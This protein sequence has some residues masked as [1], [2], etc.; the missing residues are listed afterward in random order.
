[1]I[2]AITLLVALVLSLILCLLFVPV[3]RRLAL[4][5]GL[6]DR[7]DGNRKIHD[8]TTPVSG[9]VAVLL[10]AVFT[11]TALLAFPNDLQEQLADHGLEL[12]GLLLGGLVIGAVGVVDDFCRLRGHY[13]LLGQIAAIAVVLTFCGWVGEVKLFGWIINFEMLG[14]GWFGIVFTMFL[15]LGAVNSL[16]LLDGMDGL[17]SSI[18]VIL[19]LALAAMAVSAGH[20]WAGVVAIAL[21]GALI[22]FL[23]YNLPPATIFLGDAGSM[24][25]G[26]VLGT[27]V[28]KCSLK[29]PATFVIALPVGLL[30]LPILD[31]TAAIVRRKLTGRSIYTTDRGH[32]HHSLLR[33]G[34][35]TSGVLLLV[36]MLSLVTCAGVLASQAFDNEWIAVLTAVSI[37]AVL[38]LT[39][40]FGHAEAVLIKNRLLSMLSP[41][42]H[43][44]QM[45]VRLQGSVAW[46]DL[47]QTLKVLAGELNLEQ[48]LLDVN[49]PALHE[50]YHA[51]W[52]HPHKWSEEI[53]LWHLEIPV[54]VRGVS[55]GRLV[56]AGKPDEQPVWSKIAIV[57]K[58]VDEFARP[59]PALIAVEKSRLSSS[60]ENL[61]PVVEAPESKL[62]VETL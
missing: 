13:K 61:P 47:W 42:S 12:L 60:R 46:K 10:A 2:V 24:L 62:A 41:F 14:I 53:P 3:V 23:R 16:N 57:M 18:G 1:M 7:P 51:R 50:G 28:I 36:A 6:V 21:A 20:P 4:R 27:L 25:V 48:L 34:L 11:V 49:A 17:L 19:S 52:D 43:V 58:V 44:R 40:L 9:G 30:L 29:G 33:Y 26:L 55:V 22:G 37:I 38:V 45:E 31:T 15:M 56:M 5:L 59:I 39:R 32:L 54:T 35:S 8:K